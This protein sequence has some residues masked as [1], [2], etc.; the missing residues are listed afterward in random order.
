MYQ[1]DKAAIRSISV[2]DA[3]DQH[4]YGFSYLY[5]IGRHPAINVYLMRCTMEHLQCLLISLHVDDLLAVSLC[6]RC[7]AHPYKS[8]ILPSWYY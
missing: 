3:L 7:E 5:S 4:T 1:F 2:H 6:R 8:H